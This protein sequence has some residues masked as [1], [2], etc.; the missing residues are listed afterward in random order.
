MS[1][2]SAPTIAP[3]I[4]ALMAAL[5]APF[6]AALVKFKPASV[7]GNRARAVPYIDAV[8]VQGRLDAV[9]GVA[10]WQD[11]FDVLPDGCVVCRLRIKVG[12]DWI[13]RMDVGAPSK[14]PDEGDRRKAAFSGALKRAAVKF[15]VGRYLHR[16]TPQWLDY[17][18]TKRQF[19]KPPRLPAEALQEGTRLP[20]RADAGPPAAAP[21][22]APRPAAQPSEP[23]TP[24]ELQKRIAEYETK[25]VERRL[26]RPG[27]LLQ[28]IVQSA[29]Q[30]GFA[31]D[32]STWG[33]AEIAFAVEKA[34][35]YQGINRQKVMT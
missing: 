30:R 1:A 8:V 32:L 15:G 7:S 6:D 16:V 33:P 13:A 25:L 2:P 9:L 18:P 17:D 28:W 35:S 11:E 22:T 10:G 34:R 29:V 21:T 14:Q 26:A 5:A 20:G 4:Q 31:A 23:A 12:E 3:A 19:A 24:V 27:D